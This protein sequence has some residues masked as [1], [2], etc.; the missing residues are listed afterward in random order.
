M[1][2]F[3]DFAP[4]QLSEGTFFSGPS[5]ATFSV[6]VETANA[7]IRETGVQV[8]HLETVVLPGIWNENEEGTEDGRLAVG[9][10]TGGWYQ[11][12]R[13]WYE[14]PGEAQLLAE[15]DAAP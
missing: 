5:F 3:K 11:F 8:V 15:P 7:W 13:V 4:P 12:V 9:G 2:A 1:Y 6:A 10:D 14:L